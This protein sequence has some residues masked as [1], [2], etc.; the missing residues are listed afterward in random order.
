VYYGRGVGDRDDVAIYVVDNLL[1][2]RGGI[3]QI[4]SS[5]TREAGD[6]YG[7]LYKAHQAR[8]AHW[9]THKPSDELLKR[10]DDEERVR[11]GLVVHSSSPT[12]CGFAAIHNVLALSTGSLLA[13]A[14]PP[15]RKTVK[16]TVC[17]LLRV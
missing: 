6:F 10:E 3:Q 13:L 5:V 16:E 17:I 1:K 12:I 11:Q 15:H 4:A 2:D 7:W 8:A 14:I 9:K